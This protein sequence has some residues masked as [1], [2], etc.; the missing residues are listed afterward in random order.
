VWSGKIMPGS[1]RAGTEARSPSAKH[2]LQAERP[3]EHDQPENAGHYQVDQD[4]EG[5]MSA[6]AERTV[7]TYCASLVACEPVRGSRRALSSITTSL[8]SSWGM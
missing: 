1:Y 5:G 3:G 8:V 7:V 6:H 2:S 4:Q